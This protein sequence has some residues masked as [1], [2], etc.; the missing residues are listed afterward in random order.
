[1]PNQRDIAKALG[2]NQ[3]T[4]S[5]ALRGDASISKRVQNRVREAAKRLGYHPNAYVTALMSHVRSGR[6]V[7]AKGI[8]ALLVNYTSKQ[9]W[10]QNHVYR[11]YYEGVMQRGTELGFRVESFFIQEPDMATSRIEPILFARGIQGVIVAPPNPGNRKLELH[12]E[13]YAYVGTGYPTE[14][15]Q[16][17]RVANDHYQNVAIAFRELF[18]LGYKRV[19]M[20]LPASIYNNTRRYRWVAGFLEC[21][22]RLSRGCRIPLFIGRPNEVPLDK[23]RRWHARWRPDAL[24]TIS[25]QE[26]PWLDAMSLQSP[27]DIC[28]VCLA[29]P[30]GSPFAGVEERSDCL[31]STALELV[32]AKIARNE[33]GPPSLA[34]LILIEGRWTG[35]KKIQATHRDAL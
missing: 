4:V 7:T 24:V 35:G 15:Q 11:A 2:V 30:P 32:A 19:G 23:F 20:C 12:W 8:I 16:F 10:L 14:D 9:E 29:R 17:D 22:E 26:Q 27:E 3:S 1:M 13:R 33:Y 18:Q 31:G 21:Q 25:G 28:L 5:L 34:K 6:K